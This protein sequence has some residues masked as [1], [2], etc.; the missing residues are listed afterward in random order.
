VFL[1]LVLPWPAWAGYAYE[2]SITVNRALCGSSDSAN[3]PMLFSGT[4]SYLATVA[5]GGKVQ[6][7][8]GSP[9]VPDD[10]IFTSDAAGSNLLSWEVVSY[11]ATTGAVVIWVKIPN[12]NSNADSSNTVIYL[13]Y[14][15]AAVTTFQGGATGAAWD[16]YYSGVWHLNLTPNDSTSNGINGTWNGP[17]EGTSTYYSPGLFGWAGT[18]GGTSNPDYVHFTMSFSSSTA[19]TLSAWVYPSATYSNYPYIVSGSS[20]D[21]LLQLYAGVN[22]ELVQLSPSPYLYSNATPTVGAWNYLVGTWDGSTMRIYQGG[23]LE[24]SKSASG[25]VSFANGDIGDRSSSPS[26]YAFNGLIQEA[27][28]SS[29]VRSQSWITAEYNNQSSPSTFY[30]VSG[31][32]WFASMTETQAVSDSIASHGAHFASVM[33][34]NTASDT[35]N[36]QAAFWRGDCITLNWL[37]PAGAAGN[38][39]YSYNIYRGTSP[40]NETGPINA[41]PVDA[42]CTG[43]ST[44]SYTDYGPQAGVE[45]YYTVT[46]IYNGVESAFSTETGTIIPADTIMETNTATDTLARAAAYGRGMLETDVTSDSIARRTAYMRA[47][48]ETLTFNDVVSGSWQKYV[49]PRHRG[50][51]EGRAKTG[52]ATDH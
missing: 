47:A 29:T 22:F 12:L 38:S 44:C 24:N 20:T 6:N 15:N 28:I 14:G 5:N 32:M 3:F 36:R 40:G 50:T 45:Y 31:A 25:T 23:T 52:Q 16:S 1:V 8:S 4:Y 11:S 41:S 43:L 39:A 49:Q 51:V 2:R 13:W 37:P 26:T 27:R 46:S 33:E 21:A 35:L 10:F 17:Q 9:A 19:I 42:G 7:T 30:A 48:G 34:T 18:F